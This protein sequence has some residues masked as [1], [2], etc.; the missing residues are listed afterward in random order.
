MN[1][2]SCKLTLASGWLV[3]SLAGCQSLPSVTP[4]PPRPTLAVMAQP[5][6]GMCLS[7]ED[8]ERLGRYLMALEGD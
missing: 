7:R 2:T 5:D 1:W 8:T 4:K 6:G 3:I